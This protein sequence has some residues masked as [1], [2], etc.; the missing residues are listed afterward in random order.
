MKYFDYGVKKIHVVVQ[1]IMPLRRAWET[2]MKWIDKIPAF[3]V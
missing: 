3:L 1:T 2:L